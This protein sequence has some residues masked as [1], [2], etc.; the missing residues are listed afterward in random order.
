MAHF[1]FTQFGIPFTVAWTNLGVWI[2]VIV[3]FIAGVGLRL[4]KFIEGKD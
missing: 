1:F 2:L 3:V 4:P